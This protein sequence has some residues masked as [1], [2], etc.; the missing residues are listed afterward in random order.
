MNEYRLVATTKEIFE[1]IL[2]RH[3]QELGVL[4][5]VSESLATPNSKNKGVFDAVYKFQEADYPMLQYRKTWHW[6]KDNHIIMTVE[7]HWLCVPV[8]QGLLK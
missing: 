3:A 2:R 1:S 8:Q 6:S 5:C 7:K 4:T